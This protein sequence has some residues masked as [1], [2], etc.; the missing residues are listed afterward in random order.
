MVNF[1]AT[2][3][4]KPSDQKPSSAPYS[5]GSQ[6]A[7]EIDNDPISSTNEDVV[8]FFPISLF[9]RCL[10]TNCDLDYSLVFVYHLDRRCISRG[11]VCVWLNLSPGVLWPFSYLAKG[12]LDS[13][14]AHYHYQQNSKL[15]D[16]TDS[17]D[18]S[19]NGVG[20]DSPSSA[21]K[22]VRFK[23]SSNE[24]DETRGTAPGKVRFLLATN[25]CHIRCQP[26]KFNRCRESSR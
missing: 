1:F 23:L 20:D 21:A 26:P 25:A 8:S 3:K 11:C 22:A 10:F 13:R 16:V 14:H 5:R 24:D 6:E 18:A 2:P 12:L 15:I 19:S 4:T 17:N 9:F 7:I